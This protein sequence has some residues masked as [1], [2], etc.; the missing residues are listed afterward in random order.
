[1][2]RKRIDGC[3]KLSKVVGWEANGL[4][5][6]MVASAKLKAEVVVAAVEMEGGVGGGGGVLRM[7]EK[8]GAHG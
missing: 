8:A 2:L 7:A 4:T 5:S 3:V 1:M 6:V